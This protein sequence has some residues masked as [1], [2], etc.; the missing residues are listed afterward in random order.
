MPN[1]SLVIPALSP[2]EVQQVP[3][4]LTDVLRHAGN[5]SSVALVG[6]VCSDREMFR[7]LRRLAT[8]LRN[9]RTIVDMG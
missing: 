2:E 6:I 8:Q 7:A 4:V 1:T 9:M 5:V 3:Q